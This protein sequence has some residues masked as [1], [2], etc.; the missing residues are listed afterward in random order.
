MKRPGVL[1][2]LKP[3]GTSHDRSPGIGHG[4]RCAYH[5]DE[6]CGKAKPCVRLVSSRKI[7]RGY[8]YGGR[9][10]KVSLFN[11]VAVLRHEEIHHVLLRI[12]EGKANAK[13]DG[14]HRSYDDVCR[15]LNC[16]NHQVRP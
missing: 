6:S 13:F 10:W 3:L 11:V 16:D 2:T 9:R 8:V 1:V 5:S 15:I 14:L 12:G 4:L 7:P